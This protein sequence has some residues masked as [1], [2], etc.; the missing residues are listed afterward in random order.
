VS[1]RPDPDVDALA[2]E[3][4][5]CR[6]QLS[7]VQALARIGSWEWAVSSGVVTWSDEMYR[8]AG[9]EP[10]E[11][12]DL[13]R[14][15]AV[16]HPA[17]RDR[18][19]EAVRRA[20]QSGEPYTMTHRI[21]NPDGTARV[22]VGRGEA[23]RDESGAVARLF[24]TV[25]DVTE[26]HHALELA[27]AH[28]AQEAAESAA[29]RMRFLAE[30][31]AELGAS[32]DYEAT[33]R[34]IAH[35][36]VPAIADWCAVDLSAGPA[37]VERLAVHH[38]D[39][40]KIELVQEIERRYPADPDASA[41]VPEVIRSGTPIFIREIP[42]ELLAAGAQDE[43]HLRLI[44]RLGLVSYICVPLVARGQVLGALTLVHAESGRL[45]G[46]E[47][48]ALAR[49][50]AV[51]AAIAIDNARLVRE[52]T[53]T[54]DQL[55]DQATELEHQAAE[56]QVQTATLEEQTAELHRQADAT[57]ALTE[58]REYALRELREERTRLAAIIDH[59]PVGILIA[60][61]PSGRIV[62]GN[63]AIERIFRH[64]VHYSGSV[65]EYREWTAY[66]PDGRQVRGDEYPLA[67][68]LATG[69][70]AGPSEYL[71]R[72]GDGTRAWVRITGA[73][74]RDAEGRLTAGLVV[75]DD[76]DAERRA[77]A[78]RER[79]LAEVAEE[80]KLLREVFEN[81]P[82]V[83]ALYRGPEHVVSLV[84]PTWTR[85]VG[86]KDALGRPFREVFPE[87]AETGLYEILARA[88]E[89][90]EPYSNPETNVPLDRWGTGKCED[91]YWD[92]VWLPLPW[93]ADGTRD[94]LVHA[95]ETTAQVLARRQ[96]QGLATA[97]TAVHAAPDLGAALDAVVESARSIVGAHQAVASLSVSDDRSQAI[98]AASLSEKYA[99][100]RDYAVPPDGTGIYSMV[101]ETNRSVRMTQQELEQHAHWR[102]FGEH[103]R[104]HPPMNGW[105]A[106]PMIAR[107][108]RNLGLIQLSDRYHGEFTEQDE[109][110]LTQLAQMAAVAIE[111]ARLYEE[112][113]AA[114]RA[115]SDFL[116]MM[117]HE[118]RTPLNAIGGYTELIEMG[119]HGP[120]TEAQTES[121]R[122]VKRAQEHLLGL[123]NDVL[124][125]AKLEAGR[126]EIRVAPTPLGPT[127]AD[128]ELLM[129]PQAEA[130]RIV[131]RPLGDGPDALVRA[132]PEKLQ[133]IVLNL[134]SNAIKFTDPGGE[135]AVECEARDEEVLLHVRDTG[136]G[137]PPE[138]LRSVFEPFVQVDPD[139]TRTR[140]GT[141]LGLAISRELARA[142][143]GDL[144]AESTPGR[145][146]VFTL[147]LPRG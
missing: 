126:V 84:N 136:V 12:V 112:A 22:V 34:R 108:G 67:R 75:V 32:L 30:A 103:A 42:D 16:Q 54:R 71:Y 14:Y 143:H 43:E 101:C 8:I 141:G 100:W 37:A 87:F 62:R 77:D 86:R 55:E 21:V 2:R 92:L 140:Q 51:R 95:V 3:L 116:A 70:A 110:V 114:N 89:T 57:H 66:H 17:D 44:R 11:P 91:T 133:Q 147:S 60:E 38:A 9:L 142:M 94:I 117:S 52:L 47:D 19:L 106:V 56:L 27:Q 18:V 1:L 146:S 35:L 139:L 59:A 73:P 109:A 130:K 4:S 61:A 93:R 13:D 88:Y 99:R 46:E 50:L 104:A 115:K 123:I 145:G 124:N 144:Y 65:E 64:P 83:M 6:A 10:G 122:R 36:S 72:R 132:D 81:A 24:G 98:S 135:V 69:E 127:V 90:G 63:A 7:Q 28:A 97:S 76:I 74:I 5:A 105:L 58:A 85:S 15:A 20:A 79:L 134:L 118:L 41:G 129:V 121:L 33:L 102:G 40:A 96:V 45:Y 26:S 23:E 137:I 78:E 68:V 125:F 113:V 131:Y 80:R 25:Q 138:K 82:T 49:E 107:D 31:S 53:T 39:A 111:N 128:V 119:I 120:V 29:R 48:F